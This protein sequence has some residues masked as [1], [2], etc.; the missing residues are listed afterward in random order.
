MD[1]IFTACHG[2]QLLVI[3]HLRRHLALPAAREYLLWNPMENIT[4]IDR[5]MGSVIASAEFAGVLDLRNFEQ[6]KP[7]TQGAAAWWFESARRLRSDAERLRE[8]LRINRVGAKGLELWTDDPIHFNVNFPKS[9]LPAARHVKFPHAFNLEDAGSSEYRNKVVASKQAEPWAKRFLFRPWLRAVSGCDVSASRILNFDLAYTFDKSSPWAEQSI[10]VSRLISL[11][12]FQETFEALPVGLKNGVEEA[13]EPIRAG[14]KPLVLLLLFGLSPAVGEAYK[15]A[16][17]R[18]FAE[19]A[20]QLGGCSLA[21]KMHPG[22]RGSEE[23][24][25]CEWARDVIPAQVFPIR[26]PINLEFMLPG[27]QPDYV[28][29]GPCGALPIVRRLRI[30]APIVLAEI[31]DELCRM[32]PADQTSY[33]ELVNGMQVW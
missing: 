31:M 26:S 28:L 9:C 13:L 25:F 2:T 32:F 27:F 15:K 1:R 30:G 14:P 4:T 6:L 24:K 16:L 10:D 22:A 8:W 29:A 33:R 7:R 11:E 12:R 20:Q 17:S 5:F 18:I 19:R 23:E 3:Q 21:I